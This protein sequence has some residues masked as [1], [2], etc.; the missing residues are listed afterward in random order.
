MRARE[1]IAAT[2]G[3][4]DSLRAVEWA[5]REAAL[6]Q[7]QLR[8]VSVPAL[9]PRMSHS[10]AAGDTVA[11]LIR[12]ATQR[13][14]TTAAQRARD[15][16]PGLAVSAQM[17][18]GS[19][20]RALPEIAFG[21]SMLVLGSRGTG[22]FSALLLGSVSRYAATHA[23][24][25][26][27]VAREQTMAVHRKVIVGVRDSGAAAPALG[28]A[29]EEAALRKASLLAVHASAWT[30]PPMLWPTRLTASQR[31]AV[32]TV[33]ALADTADRLETELAQWRR[34]YPQVEAALEVVCA[35]PAR[36][37][38][39]ASARADLL[40]IG[41]QPAGPAVGSITH[42]VLTHAHG[43]IAIIAAE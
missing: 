16:E 29:F 15:M 13:A 8:I 1:I 14:L 6:R 21:A 25:P 11:G 41:R 17:L 31:A 20:A 12:Q 5:A 42:A 37:L 43:P 33:Q 36:V 39:G 7:E 22:G 27:V 4:E 23:L 24:C 34:K 26:V 38:A 2:D 40:V 9:P 28:F 32:D 30:L 19:P 10:P 3:S 35:H 18:S